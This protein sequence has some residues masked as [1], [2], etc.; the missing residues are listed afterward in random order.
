MPL[1]SGVG[2]RHAVGDMVGVGCM[3]D[4]CRECAPCKAG[5]RNCRESNNRWLATSSGP[6]VPAKKAPDGKNID[7]RDNTP[8]GHSDERVVDEDFV[9]KI[10]AGLAPE[11]TVSTTPREKLPST[12]SPRPFPKCTT[13]IRSSSCSN[14][15]APWP[16]DEFPGDLDFR[17]DPSKRRVENYLDT[18]NRL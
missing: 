10:P 17:K 3:I 4:S 6:M 8:G 12:P 18:W 2:S 13:S 1:K 15:T 5:D 7:G 9:L 14:A 16:A 11:V